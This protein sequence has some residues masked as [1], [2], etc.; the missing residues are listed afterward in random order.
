MSGGGDRP[1]HA[2][3]TLLAFA[4]PGLVGHD[5]SVWWERALV[6][7]VRAGTPRVLDGEIGSLVSLLPVHGDAEG[8]RTSGLVYPLHGERLPAGT[9]RGISN[10]VATAPAAV[11]VDR[12]TLLV[13]QPDVLPAT[14]PRHTTT[15]DPEDPQR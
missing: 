3:S 5:V 4:A 15:S 10:L 14:S 8:V 9:G 7:V 2:W 11:S 13:V 1:D 6:S 12:G